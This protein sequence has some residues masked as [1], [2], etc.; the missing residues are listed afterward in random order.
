MARKSMLTAG[1]AVILGG[2]FLT[3]PAGAGVPTIDVVDDPHDVTI[4]SGYDPDD[5]VTGA[6]RRSI[7]LKWFKATPRTDDMVRFKVKIDQVLRTARFEQQIHIQMWS[8]P[9]ST[10]DWKSASFYL[11]IGRTPYA[12]A[13]LDFLDCEPH[14]VRL[15]RT[16]DTVS[17][18]IPNSCVPA[19]EAKVT[20]DTDSLIRDPESG[21][22]HA[23]SS[24]ELKV[25]AAVR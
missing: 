24:D 17:V 23:G 14:R 5:T 4:Y 7:E 16:A 10:G 15:N 25:R 9:T 19:G 2:L 21:E 13:N 6:D 11:L 22:V 20:V 1:V 12:E 3:T 18:G 8:V